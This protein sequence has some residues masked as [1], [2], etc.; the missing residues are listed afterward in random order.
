MAAKMME[1]KHFVMYYENVEGGHGAGA[2]LKQLAKLN[3]LQYEFLLQTIGT[4]LK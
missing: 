4:S 2:N 3:A 1:Q